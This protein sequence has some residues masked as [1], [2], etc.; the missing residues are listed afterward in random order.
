MRQLAL[1]ILLCCTVDVSAQIAV[2]IAPFWEHCDGGP[3]IITFFDSATKRY[4]MRSLQVDADGNLTEF[5]G[6]RV[7]EFINDSV[8][9]NSYFNYKGEATIAY[10]KY[11]PTQAYTWTYVDKN[12][13]LFKTKKRPAKVAWHSYE[14][15]DIEDGDSVYTIRRWRVS[16]RGAKKDSVCDHIS[17]TRMDSKG[18]AKE[19]KTQYTGLGCNCQW[20]CIAEY[21]VVKYVYIP[22]GEVRSERTLVSN[23]QVNSRF[24]STSKPIENGQ[25]QLLEVQFKT[26]DEE[27][28]GSKWKFKYR[29]GLCCRVEYWSNGLL[30]E[31]DEL[32]Y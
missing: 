13:E 28:P 22:G 29:G 17:T 7:S 9:K 23:Q 27:T 6:R 5:N 18:R 30:Q 11:T 1:L 32:V 4:E 2:P 3:P 25:G 21:E 8:V 24:S 20:D 19:R 26:N 16:G 10:Y 31:I 15:Y 12:G 14:A